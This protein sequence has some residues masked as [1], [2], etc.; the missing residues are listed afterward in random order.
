MIF[1]G[2][3]DEQSNAY[4]QI[5][6]GKNVF[7]TGQPGTGKSHLLRSIFLAHGHDGTT[8]F[9]VPTGM[10]AR[11]IGGVT[12]HSFFELPC[13]PILDTPSY[14][15]PRAFMRLRA[16]E[17]L[18]V[19]EVSMVRSDIF[20]A[21]DRRMRLAKACPHLPFGGC[22]VVLCG[23]FHQLPPVVESPCL[24][25][26]LIKAYGG[27]YAFE[28]ETWQQADL[29]S[30]ILKQ[31]IRQSEDPDFIAMLNAIRENGP[32]IMGAIATL[33]SQV[34]TRDE[35]TPVLCCRRNEAAA[36]NHAMLDSIPGSAVA[37]KARVHVFHDI[38]PIAKDLQ[39]LPCD[40]KI[41]LKEGCKVM[42]LRNCPGVCVNGDMGVVESWSDD[43]VTVHLQNSLTTQL[44]R[45]EW[46]LYT[47][48]LDVNGKLE[49]Q[50]IASVWQFPLT[51]G[52]AT[53]IHKAQGSTLRRAH[54]DIGVGC[55]E[56]GQ[57][58]VALSRVRHLDDLTLERAV[59]YQDLAP[60]ALNE[61][62]TE[63]GY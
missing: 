47:Y 59:G 17:V 48:S 55:W 3:T 19:D 29:Q 32:E 8:A 51:L 56:S 36:I 7:L 44:Q 58:Y 21:M 4:F 22:Q 38:E 12:I 50:H 15:S 52:Y 37:F 27:I 53:T 30:I 57:L 62:L 63:L 49:I 20:T 35:D 10:A 34:R 13:T 31:Q 26:A 43:T 6:M 14:L 61:R 54:I 45:V 16:C 33:N 39:E 42:V 28:T 25:E 23:D 5:S 41:V 24:V 18:I 9:V 2:L 1:K 40:E 60:S 46:P 11:N